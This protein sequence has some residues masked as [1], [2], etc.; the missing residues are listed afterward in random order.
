MLIKHRGFTCDI[1][2]CLWSKTYKGEILFKGV[3]HGDEPLVLGKTFEEAQNKFLDII[4]TY[5]PIRRVLH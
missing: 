2:H 5:I 4:D 1:Y 3:F